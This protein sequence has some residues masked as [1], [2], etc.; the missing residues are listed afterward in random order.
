MNL[1]NVRAAPQQPQQGDNA[2]VPS[3]QQENNGENNEEQQQ[4]SAENEITTQ[5]EPQ[6]PVL[7]V[8]K[9]FLVSFVA[10]IIPTDPA[11]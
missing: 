4:Q 9:T 6:V 2:D 7:E 5:E 3:Q 10:S 1:N 8:V 11:I